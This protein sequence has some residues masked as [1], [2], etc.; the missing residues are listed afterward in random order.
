MSDADELTPPR[1]LSAYEVREQAVAQA[2]VFG[3]V[4][5]LVEQS[6]VELGVEMPEELRSLYRL[7]Q[8]QCRSDQAMFA[9]QMFRHTYALASYL[10]LRVEIQVRRALHSFDQYLASRPNEIG[11][12]PQAQAMLGT[13]LKLQRTLGE[14]DQMNAAS[15]R[16][17][18]LTEA[19]S[20]RPP[21]PRPAADKP[22]PRKS[23]PARQRAR[24]PAHRSRQPATAGDARPDASSPPPRSPTSPPKFSR[25]P[26]EDDRYIYL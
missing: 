4:D 8:G 26:M 9:R 16:L 20:R 15:E 13:L 6:A 17:R 14:L 10:T 23:P 5:A 22:R 3:L 21:Q 1:K 11:L 7:I 25:L 19:R 2:D 24:T 18:G 12:P